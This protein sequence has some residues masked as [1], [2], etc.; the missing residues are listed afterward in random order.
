MTDFKPIRQTRIY[1]EVVHQ[2]KTAI[3]EHRYNPGEKLPSE[4]QLCDQFQVSR[5]VIREAIRVLELTGFVTLKQ[6]P[7]GGAYVRELSFDHLS[8]AFRD[9]FLMDKLSGLEVLD[10]RLHIEP[11]VAA[12]A[13]KNCTNGWREKLMACAHEYPRGETEDSMYLDKNMEVHRILPK[14]TGNRLYEAIINPIIDL[15]AEM[16][17]LN[18]D[19]PEFFGKHG[20]HRDI[21]DAVVS[22]DADHAADAVRDHLGILRDD[23]ANLEKEY[24]IKMGLSVSGEI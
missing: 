21:V 6:G 9:L 7:S 20:D 1:E 10:V 17:L 14:M 8:G 4:R 11:E 19:K 24:R 22:G 13:A 3:L 16:I 2:L 12:I 15:T 23:I 18:R 5:V